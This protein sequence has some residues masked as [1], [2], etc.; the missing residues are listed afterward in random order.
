MKSSKKNPQTLMQHVGASLAILLAVAILIGDNNQALGQARRSK[1]D[2]KTPP[3]YSLKQFKKKVAG[4]FG[5]FAGEPLT[6]YLVHYVGSTKKFHYFETYG[7]KRP[8]YR[9]SRKELPKLKLEDGKA[10][11]FPKDETDREYRVDK[12]LNLILG[13][14]GVAFKKIKLKDAAKQSIKLKFASARGMT[15]IQVEAPTVHPKDK[16]LYLSEISI[17][18]TIHA[19]APARI[20]DPKAK[21]QKVS[22][23]VETAELKNSRLRLI[24]ATIPGGIAYDISLAEAKKK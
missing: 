22:L 11:E 10:I 12:N 8:Y 23:K 6:N 2:S 13:P 9:V 19:P 3:T 24:Y 20:K 14:P 7:D 18:H 1:R 21:I 15:T 17:L 16:G 4:Q 5:S